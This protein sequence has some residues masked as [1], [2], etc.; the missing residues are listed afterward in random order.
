MAVSMRL[1]E[2]L[3]AR[4]ARLRP[5]DV[6]VVPLPGRRRVAGLR[7]EELAQ[8]AGV[9]VSYYTR[10]EQGQ[11]VN[12]SEGVL[13][14]L[15]TALRLDEH[16][17]TH[18]HELASQRP[19]PREEP[20]A[21]RVDA[22]TRDLMR[23]LEDAPALVLGR[24]TDVL[25][26]NPL[27][28]ALLA[29]HV[30]P[31]APDRPAD[32]PNL[33]RML[34]LDPHTRELYAD[35]ARKARAVVGNLRQVAGRHPEDALLASLIGEL[36]MKAPEFAALWSDHRVR[37]CEADA[38]LLRHP[39]VGE[40]TVTQ[41]NLLVTRSPGQSLALVTTEE[42]SSSADTIE[43]LRTYIVEGGRAGRFGR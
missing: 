11:S 1:S 19:R 42:G 6:G 43:L 10:L 33:A 16:E 27:A 12:A 38:Y 14:A 26:W 29:G 40:L 9:S 13:D 22:L 32:R 34:F 25:A 5:E 8:V 7:R 41:Q 30:D 28:H 23:S 39:L 2:F 21:E 15:A 20:P 35:W 37:P 17:R 18:L 24:R 36:S 3:Q 4:R 31:T